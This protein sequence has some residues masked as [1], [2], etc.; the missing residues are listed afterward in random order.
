MIEFFECNFYQS[1]LLILFKSKYFPKR[2]FLSN[3]LIR[4]TEFYTDMKHMMD[5]MRT[6]SYVFT[7]ETCPWGTDVWS[8]ML[9]TATVIRFFAPNLTTDVI[10]A[11][12]GRCPISWLSTR[13]PFTH[14]HEEKKINKYKYSG[15][16]VY[17]LNSGWETWRENATLEG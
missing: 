8:R 5:Q 15:C 10:S 9:S 2:Y 3:I 16:R 11:W 1:L 13:C 4:R 6:I 7:S 12:K 14:Y 17:M